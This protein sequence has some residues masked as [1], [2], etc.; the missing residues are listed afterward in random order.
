MKLLFSFC[1]VCVLLPVAASASTTFTNT[2]NVSTVIPDNDDV[3]FTTS[4][5]V[6]DTGMTQIENV[7]VNLNF[8]GGWNGDLYVYLVH[9]SGF[10]VLLN[11]PG[12]SLSA[13]D[14]SGTVG[15]EITFD[16]NAATDLHTAIPLTGGSVSGT[17]Q[18]DGRITDPLLVLNTDARPAMLSSFVSLNANGNWTLFVADQSPG[19]TATL[20]SWGLSITAVPEPSAALLGG[21]GVLALLRRRRDDVK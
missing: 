14:G 4:Q 1:S 5:N 11:R 10:S 17:F 2:W 15:M 12:R 7:T 18:P 16:D 19:D 13:L 21:L 3:G 8:A 9:G 20:T 6:S